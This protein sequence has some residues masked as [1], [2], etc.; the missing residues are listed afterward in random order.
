MS[1]GLGFLR[2]IDRSYEKSHRIKIDLK[3]TSYQLF[4]EVAVN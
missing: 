2:E 3:K 1:V 4:Y